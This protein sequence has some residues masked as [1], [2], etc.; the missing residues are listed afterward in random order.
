[1]NQTLTV[2]TQDHLKHIY[3]LTESGEHASTN[4]LAERLNVE[5]AS[6]TN[7]IQKLASVAPAL[8]DY[9]RHQGVT[10]TKEGRK[11]ALEVVRS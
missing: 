11:A 4:A 7:M 2:S 3:E 5:A 8:V 1:M 9:Q 6:V 10:L